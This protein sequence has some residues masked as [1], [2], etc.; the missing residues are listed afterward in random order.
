MPSRLAFNASNPSALRLPGRSELSAVPNRDV[1][2]GARGRRLGRRVPNK[3]STASGALP[4]D[5]GQGVVD[6]A[7]PQETR[8]PG[9]RVRSKTPSTEPRALPRAAFVEFQIPSSCGVES[10]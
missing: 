8:T 4:I 2:S 6:S 7:T 10:M 1:G 9:V 5:Q 3:S